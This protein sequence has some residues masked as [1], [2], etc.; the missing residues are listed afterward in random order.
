MKYFCRIHPGKKY[1][2]P[3]KCPNCG[4][5]LIILEDAAASRSQADLLIPE[6]YDPAK[7]KKLPAPVQVLLKRISSSRERSAASLATYAAVGMKFFA[8]LG[9]VRKPTEQDWH[10]YFMVRRRQGVSERTRA[11]EFYCLKRLAETNHFVW[12]FEKDDAPRPI[13]DTEVPVFSVEQV[14]QL[15]KAWPHY[16]TAERF[17]LACATVW[18]L[19]SNELV[20]IR[21]R[22]Y[23]A[24]SVVFHKSKREKSPRRLLPD[25]LKSLFAG[26]R[27]SLSTTKGAGHLFDRICLKAGVKRKPR[28]SWHSIRH[29]VDTVLFWATA[30]HKVDQSLIGAWMN[31]SRARRGVSFGGSAMAGVYRNDE[32]VSEDPYRTDRIIIPIHPFLKL[33]EGVTPQERPE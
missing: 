26:A 33:W 11:K 19:R 28:Q 23:D 2:S 15:I 16:T 7:F 22:D 17:Y 6:G 32:A 24:K 3:G 5:W 25:Q 4:R 1:T 10:D 13:D 21:K 9:E 8:V 14:E 30:E 27:P 31:W 20:A 29:S 18:G 12:P